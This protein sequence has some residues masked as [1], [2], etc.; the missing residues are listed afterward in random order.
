[1]VLKG[2][3]KVCGGQVY[4]EDKSPTKSVPKNCLDLS[5]MSEH[6]TEPEFCL[7]AKQMLILYNNW[8][9]N[10]EGLKFAKTLIPGGDWGLLFIKALQE[11][12]FLVAKILKK[13]KE[14]KNND[15]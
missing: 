1:M 7:N 14:E 6:I 8:T 3:C 9:E 4:F 13:A 15:K 12:P 10:S 2:F 5:D 11:K